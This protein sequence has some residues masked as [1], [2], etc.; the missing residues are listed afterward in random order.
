[1]I[2]Q[3][4]IRR[5]R[6][7][8]KSQEAFFRKSAPTLAVGE[9]A[10]SFQMTGTPAAG[11]YDGT[12]APTQFIGNKTVPSHASGLIFFNNA[13]SP[14]QNFLTFLRGLNAS[15]SPSGILY[16][17]DLLVEYSGF[18][19][20]GPAEQATG[21]A[22]G[23]NNLPRYTDGE[24]ILIYADV[25]T[26]LGVSKTLTVR[27]TDQG[28]LTGTTV[29]IATV[30]AQAPINS[31]GAVEPFLPLAAGDRGVKSIQGATL[32]AGGG[33]GTFAL[34]LVKKLASIRVELTSG[35]LEGD[36]V[37]LQPMLPKLNDD[38]CLAFIWIPSA[39]NTALFMLDGECIA[40]D[41]DD[42]DA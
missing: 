29:G 11:V 31:V 35:N 38:A 5:A 34:V 4:Q 37:N 2:T 19:A 14:E 7:K 32:T 33:A 17:V 28:G 30:A 36:F 40:L 10:L 39:G 27:Y 9:A 8:G 13:I 20:N 24:G 41:P 42:L 18:I 16:L 3:E 6:A 25:I 12:L 15:A 1:M 23:D 26:A 22:T 21:T